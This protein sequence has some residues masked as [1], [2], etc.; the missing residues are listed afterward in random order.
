MYKKLIL[1]IVSISLL[2]F[3][4][5]AC[6]SSSSKEKEKNVNV[7]DFSKEFSKR[8]KGSNS[9]IF[10]KNIGD[11]EKNED[12][13]KIVLD[14]DGNSILFMDVDKNN[15]IT[16]ASLATASKSIDAYNSEL[17]IA[18]N[19]LIQTTDPSLDLEKTIE[20]K[21]KLKIP[22]MINLD[23]T[24]NVQQYNDITYTYYVN[25]DAVIFEVKY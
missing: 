20:I 19:W 14:A 17:H 24:T 22:D 4:L 10:K 21:D 12:G 9:L 15:N 16:N 2:S 7:E 3:V 5:V 18:Y 6:S 23:A 25:D 8:I 11:L 1:I 13:Y